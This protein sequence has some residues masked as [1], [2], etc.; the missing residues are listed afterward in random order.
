MSSSNSQSKI[1]KLFFAK[2]FSIAFLDKKQRYAHLVFEIRRPAPPSENRSPCLTLPWDFNIILITF[3]Y[4]PNKHNS[5]RIPIRDSPVK[6]TVPEVCEKSLVISLTEGD[7]DA[8]SALYTRFSGPLFGRIIRLVKS[9]EIAEELLQDLFLR[10]WEKRGQIDAE[11]PFKSYLFRIA[12]NLVY[13]HFRKTVLEQHFQNDLRHRFRDEYV[14]VLEEVTF[15][16]SH[17]ALMK[18][19]H[20]LPPQ[21]RKVFVLFKLEGMSYKEIGQLLKINKSTINNHLYK[22]NRIMR[23]HLPFYRPNALWPAFFFLSHVFFC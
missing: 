19:I 7:Y 8:F 13:D 16:E 23:Q 15:K 18:S 17:Q 4:K 5:L 22:A 2:E 10:V 3:E 14:H 6:K 20:R 1:A 11:R 12:E 21:C 9:C